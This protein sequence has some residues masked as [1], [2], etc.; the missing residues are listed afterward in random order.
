MIRFPADTLSRSPDESARRIATR[1]LETAG[2]ALSRVSDPSDEEALHDFRV[3]L[4]RLSSTLMAY[5]PWLQERA[6]DRA[7][8][9]IRELGGRTNHA[10]DY[11][12]QIEWLSARR[13]ALR[14]GQRF[15][16][17]RVVRELEADKKRAYAGVL[18]GILEEFEELC[19][20]LRPKLEAYRAWVRLDE[21]E[22]TNSFARVSG[23]LVAEHAERLQQQLAQV[24]TP[25]D[26]AHAHQAR[27]Q[28]KRLRYLVEPLVPHVEGGR[29]VLRD[30]K[31]LQGLL[32]EFNDL[33]LLER[34]LAAS[35]E[36][37]EIERAHGLIRAA[38]TGDAALER[39][40]KRRTGEGGLL[41][42]VHAV[43][44]RKHGLFTDLAAKW[45][46]D[47]GAAYAADFRAFAQRLSAHATESVEIE[48][49]YLLRALPPDARTGEVLEI[50]QG[51]LPGGRVRDRLRRVRGPQGERFLRT[52]KLG[53]GLK[54]S[55]FEEAMAAETFEQLW[56]LTEG[57]RV[58][59]RRYR[60][61]E[62]EH[63]WEIDAFL[64]RDL[65]L[66]EVELSSE[67]EQ[68]PVPDW[69]APYVEREVTGDPDFSNVHLAL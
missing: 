45:L 56:P 49:K 59:K 26:H 66:A 32:G 1:L 19:A 17:E 41:A 39:R 60:V 55:E 30:L 53:E 12:V 20:M 51:W 7:V 54:R 24:R 46:G 35:L 25:S 9:R 44:Q 62:G 48:R 5:R 21:G 69:L 38:Q 10:R 57:Q 50:E 31:S 8:S 64:D 34:T 37:A 47:Q 63:V 2:E 15:A 65:V 33:V 4:R 42:L 6:A 67:D 18:E 13:A 11:E 58:R 16:L 61:E 68:A 52:L 29:A 40:V 27:I 14:P 36:R 3:S 43:E 28:A 23:E 22:A